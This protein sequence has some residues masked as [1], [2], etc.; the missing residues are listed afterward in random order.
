M[1]APISEQRTLLELQAAD[2]RLAQL[3]HRAKTLPQQKR[4]DELAARI[5]VVSHRLAG[6]NGELEDAQLEI[7]RVESDVE[8]VTARLARDRSRLETS[9]STKDIQGLEHEIASLQKRESDLEDIELAVMERMDEINGRLAVV[10]EEMATL[11]AERDEL[12]TSRDADLAAI[13]SE[14][15]GVQLNRELIAG[16]VGDELLALYNRQRERYGIGAALLTRGV[17]MGSNVKLHESD[18]AKIRAAAPDDVVLDP[19]SSCILVRT[20]ESGL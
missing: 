12:Q 14:I 4:L 15:A 5:G 6:A 8:V 11:V 17:S 9:S 20:E 7:S 13:D 1:K 18:L 3:G 2:T 10:I 16:G 19:D